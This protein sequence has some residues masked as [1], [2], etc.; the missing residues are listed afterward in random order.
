MEGETST[1]IGQSEPQRS[2]GPAANTKRQAN[3][4]GMASDFKNKIKMKHVYAAALYLFIALVIFSPIVSNMST[5]APGTGGDLYSNLWGIWWA[6]YTVFHTHGNLWYTYLL[7][8]PVGSN[9]A[10]Y[11]FS[12][13]GAILTAPFQAI[14]VTFAYDIIFFLGFLLSGLSMFILAD[15]IVKNGYAAFIAGIIFS[16]S[17]FHV[18]MSIGHLDWMNIGFVPLALY[19]FIRMIKD[20]HK[21]VWAVGLGASFVLATFMGDVEQGI[22]TVVLLAVVFICYLLNSSTRRLFKNKK[23]WAAFG[24]AI[25]AAF[26]I[27]AWGWIPII[28]GYTAPGGA[29]NINSRNT[30]TNDVEWS[31]P[32]LS[33][34]LP[35]PY[36]GLLYKLTSGYSSIYSVDPDERIA[37]IGYTAIILV[38]FG[39]WKNFKASKL[40]IVVALFFGWMVLG[41]YVQVG[42]Y[43]SSGVPGIYYL[44][45]FIPGFGVLQ[46]ADRFYVAFSIAIAMLSAIGMKSLLERFNSMGN[47]TNM[48]AIVGVFTVLFLAESAGVMTGAFAKANTTVVTV[49]AFYQELGNYTANFSILQLPIIINNNVQYP[50]LAAGQATFYTSASHKPILG[51]YGGRINLTEQLPLFSIPLAVAVYNLQNGNASYASPVNENYTAQTLLALYNYNVGFVV[52][53]RQVLNTSELNYVG[54]LAESI[55]GSPVYV[56]NSTIV[57]STEQAINSSVYRSYASYPFLTDWE[58]VETFINGTSVVLWEPV[59]PGLIS[60]FAPYQN[61]TNILYKAFS[62]GVYRINTTI[63]FDAVALGGPTTLLIETPSES[64]YQTLFSANLTNTP[65]HYEFNVSM[66]SGPDGNPLLFVY[67]GEGVPGLSNITFGEKR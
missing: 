16:F 64:S 4:M 62:S 5:T 39:L 30:L 54:S 13:I 37:Y 66:V 1:N 27:G 35:S 19:F 65:G 55:F 48:L 52:V 45:H 8:W 38:L 17:S 31:S 41:P 12:P 57:F 23:L 36:N 32:I 51:G 61:D 67:G 44:Y 24:V 63:S 28:K 60:V 56:D 43:I 7:F 21:Y 46:E 29:A 34:L 59:S 25:V 33:F 26:I 18:A 53:N 22:L 9:I 58:E 50:D 15:Y 6:S 2:A 20:G 42:Q 11:T 10:Y 47:K 49:P 40:W 3:A 14:S